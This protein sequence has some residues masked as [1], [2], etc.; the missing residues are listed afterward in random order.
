LTIRGRHRRTG[1]LL[2][3][4]FN[5]LWTG[6]AVSQLGDYVAYLTVP[7]F[8]LELVRATSQDSRLPFA[9]TYALEQVPVLLVGF[10]GGVLLDRLRLRSLMIGADLARAVVFL[11][12]AWVASQP[13]GD[14]T[15]LV[16]FGAAFLFG[17]FASLFGSALFAFVPALVTQARLAT[18][19]GRIAATQQVMMALG[20]LL[21]GVTVA[22]VTEPFDLVVAG[23]NL[24]I[25]GFSLAF[26][27]N[28]VTFVVSAISLAMIGRVEAPATDQEP[29][30]V[31]AE[32]VEGFRFLWTEPR[33]RSS[34]L[35]AAAANLATGFIEATFVVLAADLVGAELEWQIGALLAALGVG[36]TI[37]ALMASRSSRR[38]GL[39]RTMTVGLVGFGLAFLA[40]LATD[41]GVATI[42]LFALA[43]FAFAPTN[44]ALVTIRQAYTPARMLG[45]V[46]AASRAIGW[47]TLPVGALAG[48][49]LSDVVGLAPVAVAAALVPVATAGALVFTSI[50]R[51]AF[52]PSYRT[53]DLTD[54]A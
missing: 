2:G 12:L 24:V 11:G 31:M 51:D 35:A 14:D 44:V 50:W 6:Q 16:V 19:N 34:T 32:A 5:L 26:A 3:R 27:F 52:G 4:R 53:I 40:G 8:V 9:F 13:T 1:S 10:F 25:N 33:L 30:G 42:L 49:A 46:T 23:R 20:P 45:R 18:A 47:A 15:F 21:A 22:A 7:L 39:G 17:T 29:A 28:A 48:A 37:G 43:F 41:F 36:G 54:A 38:I